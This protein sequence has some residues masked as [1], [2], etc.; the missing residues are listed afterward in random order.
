MSLS[1]E[2]KIIITVTYFLSILFSYAIM[3]VVMSFNGGLFLATIFGL[4]FGH[5][6][7]GYLKKKNQAVAKAAVGTERIYNPE[8]DKCCADVD[9]D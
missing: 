3:L 7:F 4:G 9:F 1:I 6:V 2:Q 5:F 8:G